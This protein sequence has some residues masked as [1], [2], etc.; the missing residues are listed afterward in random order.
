MSEEE[1]GIEPKDI[2]GGGPLNQ[3][4]AHAYTE[5]KIFVEGKLPHNLLAQVGAKLK[6]WRVKTYRE[7]YSERPEFSK[8]Y[9]IDPMVSGPAVEAADRIVAEMNTLLSNPEA[10]KARL[11]ELALALD[12]IVYKGEIPAI[13]PAPPQKE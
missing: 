11:G 10:N 9:G 1:K 7:R 3:D 4:Y 12:A 6:G 13:F 2:G 5:V 8:M